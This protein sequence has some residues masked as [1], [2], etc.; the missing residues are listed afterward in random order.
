[1]T[2]GFLI[3]VLLSSGRAELRQY[4]GFQSQEACESART[5]RVVELRAE[6]SAGRLGHFTPFEC[7]SRVKDILE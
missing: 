3:L 2:W 4:D 5:A 6:V 7:R 1:M